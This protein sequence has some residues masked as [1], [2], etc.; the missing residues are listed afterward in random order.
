MELVFPAPEWQ[1]SSG[2]SVLASPRQDLW[3]RLQPG[4]G[5]AACLGRTGEAAVQGASGPAA[6]V[7][8]AHLGAD[9][10]ATGAPWR[11]AMTLPRYHGE[12]LLETCCMSQQKAYGQI[13]ETSHSCLLQR[14][15]RCYSYSISV[16][17][18]EICFSTHDLS[19]SD[20]LQP[21]VDFRSGAWFLSHSICL[22]WAY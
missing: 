15:H 3:T 4:L 12:H 22:H 16:G 7:T 1:R 19:S 21:N 8:A 9:T 6:A 11:E 14:T 10:V 2:S 5:S 17:N 18:V 20:R 13:K